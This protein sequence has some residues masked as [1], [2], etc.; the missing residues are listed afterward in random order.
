L[1]ASK[2]RHWLTRL[3]TMIYQRWQKKNAR[4]KELA[5]NGETVAD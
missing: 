1:E 2:D 4:Q 5:V 3:S